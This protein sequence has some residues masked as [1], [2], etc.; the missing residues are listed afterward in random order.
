[1]N[2]NEEQLAD[3]HQSLLLVLIRISCWILH[4]NMPHCKWWRQEIQ[5]LMSV[6][7][8]MKTCCVVQEITF[9][10]IYHIR[11]I[12]YFQS[13]IVMLGY[14]YF[15]FI[16]HP[17]WESY[18][19]LGEAD[20]VQNKAHVGNS[21]KSVWLINLCYFF[22]TRKGLYYSPDNPQAPG[23][24]FYAV[25]PHACSTASVIPKPLCKRNCSLLA[26]SLKIIFINA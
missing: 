17:I 6:Y 12:W 14:I 16:K 10:L 20:K 21:I 23:T 2:G 7:S 19:M 18:F 22:P 1:M 15:L 3:D 4:W 26:Y 9:L 24:C 25:I 11:Y 8:F 5:S 13:P